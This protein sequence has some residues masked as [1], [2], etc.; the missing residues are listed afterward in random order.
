MGISDYLK[1]FVG[2][3]YVWGGNTPEQGFDCSGLVCEGLRIT[4]RSFKDRSAQELHDVLV[5]HVVRNEHVN[6][7]KDTICFFGKELNNIT[8]VGVSIGH[9]LMIEAGGEGITPTD[10]GFVRIR[11]IMNRGDLVAAFVLDDLWGYSL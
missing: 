11:P 5:E 8:H 3:K 9:G 7:S 1:M 2:T 4:C 6:F 10:K